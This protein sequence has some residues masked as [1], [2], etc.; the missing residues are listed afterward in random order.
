MVVVGGAVRQGRGGRGGV[1]REGG[2][3]AAGTL[4]TP[5]LKDIIHS[6]V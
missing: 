5:R 6:N 3:E 2:K 4:G 1:R